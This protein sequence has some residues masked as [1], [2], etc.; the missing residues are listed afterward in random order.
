MARRE[1]DESER[2]V[3][4][5]TE[6]WVRLKK[7]KS[8]TDWIAVG[9]GMMIGRQQ[10]MHEAG[11]N[12]PKGRG[13][14]V[15]FG[16]WL[17]DH[18]FDDMDESDRAKLFKIMESRAEVEAWRETLTLTDK[19]RLNHPS[20][21]YR[22]WKGASEVGDEPKENKQRRLVPQAKAE[23]LQARVDEL[24]Q[25]L[26]QLRERI[27]ELEQEN[28]NLHDRLDKAAKPSKP[29]PNLK[30]KERKTEPASKAE[31]DPL[32]QLGDDFTRAVFGNQ[33][34]RPKAR[35]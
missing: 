12:Q 24:L 28:A 35:R 31:T 27:T 8:W 2:I 9:E 17:K 5:A 30:G 33:S 15:V 7:D 1:H 25:E 22:K 4:Q 26:E 32:T 10:A 29:T 20:S 18:K 34:K 23:Q 16:K 3:R 13:F 6:A 11:T 14:N 21:V 19:M